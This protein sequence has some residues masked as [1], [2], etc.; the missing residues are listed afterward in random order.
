MGM[1]TY[2][3]KLEKTTFSLQNLDILV[4]F[5]IFAHFIGVWTIWIYFVWFEI[6]GTS[7]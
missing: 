5:S 3:K 2:E 7:F 1:Y 4:N 6:L